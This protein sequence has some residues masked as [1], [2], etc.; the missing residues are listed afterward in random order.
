M[1]WH[2]KE[3]CSWL[4]TTTGVYNL[5]HWTSTQ[6]TPTHFN[7]TQLNFNS[8]RNS[9]AFGAEDSIAQSADVGGASPKSAGGQGP[10][11]FTRTNTQVEGVD[12]ADFVKT[13]GTQVFVLTGNQLYIVKSWPAETMEKQASLE[14]EGQPVEMFLEEE[15]NRLSIISTIYTFN[16]SQNEGIR[17]SVSLDCFQWGSMDFK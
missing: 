6:R 7:S 3:I 10:T 13:N 14:L 8:T 1:D 17:E 2:Q 9:I 16:S 4:R 5:G 15:E 12:E 11:A